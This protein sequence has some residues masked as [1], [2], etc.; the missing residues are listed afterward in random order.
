MASWPASAAAF[1]VLGGGDAKTV[2]RDLTAEERYAAGQLL[3]VWLQVAE[4]E[5]SLAAGPVR[6]ARSAWVRQWGDAK[7]KPT[8]GIPYPTGGPVLTAAGTGQAQPRFGCA[9]VSG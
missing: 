6:S 1:E 8:P 3:A 9:P 5:R 2:G 4:D 7:P